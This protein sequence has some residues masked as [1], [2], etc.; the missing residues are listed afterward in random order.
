MKHK[1]FILVILAC[2]VC[3]NVFTQPIIKAQRTIGGNADDRLTSMY[4]T[5]DGG[6]IAGGYSNSNKSGEKTE[7]SQGLYA[8]WIV[9][10]DG[11]LNI[12]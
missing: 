3:T 5:K 4:L 10:M 8:F 7:S 9:K 2:I 1:I 12:Q 6:L 11:S